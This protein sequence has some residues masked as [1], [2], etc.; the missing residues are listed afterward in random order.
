M[1]HDYQYSVESKMIG[2]LEDDQHASNKKKEDS[3][4]DIASKV[5]EV[6]RK[7]LIE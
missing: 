6:S 1:K 2:H 5:L 3:D 4:N 7:Y